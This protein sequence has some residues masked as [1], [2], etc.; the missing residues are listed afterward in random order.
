[1]EVLKAANL[2]EG[3]HL[4]QMTPTK[5]ALDL[6]NSPGRQIVEQKKCEFWIENE[7]FHYAEHAMINYLEGEKVV[8]D[9]RHFEKKSFSIFS[10]ACSMSFINKNYDDFEEY[11]CD[12]D[13]T[14]QYFQVVLN[15]GVQGIVINLPS[16]KDAN[17]LYDFIH[18][19]M[20]EKK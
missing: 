10:C 14:Y 12:D 8:Q 11:L 6:L 5:V 9:Y 1:M 16:Q 2:Y 20:I 18:Q 4:T 19:Q 15:A 13:T 7:R 17:W 3:K